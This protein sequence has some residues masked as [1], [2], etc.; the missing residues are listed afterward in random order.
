[1][2][3]SNKVLASLV[4]VIAFPL[5]LGACRHIEGT[6]GTTGNTVGEAATGGV[7]VGTTWTQCTLVLGVGQKML[8]RRDKV[9]FVD[10]ARIAF[11]GETFARDTDCRSALSESAA[12]SEF[13]TKNSLHRTFDLGYKIGPESSKPGVYPI[14]LIYGDGSGGTTAY[15]TALLRKDRLSISATCNVEQVYTKTCAAVTGRSPETRANRLDQE[16]YLFDLY[17]RGSAD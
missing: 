3:L 2:S 1:M 15:T 5:Y 11:E 10:G 13:G 7:L 8:Y 6:S 16:A 9:R 14:D 17:R 4:A 12:Y